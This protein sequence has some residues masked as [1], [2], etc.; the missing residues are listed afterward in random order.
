MKSTLDNLYELL[1]HSDKTIAFTGAGI[2]TLSGIPDFRGKNG[3]YSKPWKGLPVEEILS[4]DLFDRDPEPFYEWARNFV[5]RCNEFDPSDVHTGLAALERRGLLDRVYTQNIDLLHTK[6]GSR[7][8]VELHGSPARHSCRNCGATCGYDEVA[9]TV[10]EGKVPRCKCG[11][12]LKPE[13][14][15]YGENL[16]EGA[17]ERGIEDFGDAS[18]VL[19]LGSSLTVHPAAQLPMISARSGA[20][21]VIVNATPTCLDDQAAMRFEDLKDVFSGIL[22]RYGG[23]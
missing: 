15:F 10:L 5:Y 1:E 4:I 16:P 6:A 21:L 3:F 23:R 17:F 14:T 12:V 7:S 9:K 2:S 22:E 19:V 8:I 11:G 20:A 13:I 18:V